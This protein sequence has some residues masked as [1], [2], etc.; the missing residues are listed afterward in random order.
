MFKEKM[1][2]RFDKQKEI[3]EKLYKQEVYLGITIPDYKIT[4][5]RH[6]K[7]KKILVLGAGTARDTKFLAGENDVYAIDFSNRATSYLK[8]IG[9]KASRSNLNKP[10]RFQNNTFDIVVAKDIL[11]HLDEPSRLAGEIFRVL[12]PS[13]YA[14]INVPNH[15][16]ISMRLRMLFG[17]NIIWK[18]FGHDQTKEFD[19]WNY[20]HKIFFT[21][22]GFKKMLNKNHFKIDKTFFDFGTLNHYSQPEMV[23][24]YL[25]AKND[26]MTGRLIVKALKYSWGFLNVVFPRKMRS[27]IVSLSPSLFCASFYIWCS[28]EK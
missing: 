27:F 15:F 6:I 1:K 4:N 26:S 13:G 22:K 8:K 3:Y 25:L 11:E 14:V 28:P 17:K 10:L 2:Q 21:W 12:R 20:M 19:E 5:G 7:N 18:T 24:T 23:F 9:I 16:Y